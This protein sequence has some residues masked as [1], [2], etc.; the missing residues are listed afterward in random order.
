LLPHFD[1]TRA[2][3]ASRV[4]D[5]AFGDS[6]LKKTS[7]IVRQAL[8][9]LGPRPAGTVWARPGYVFAVD[10]SLLLTSVLTNAVPL[11]ADHIGLTRLAEDFLRASV[12]ILIVAVHGDELGDAFPHDGDARRLLLRRAFVGA[13]GGAASALAGKALVTAIT[14]YTAVINGFIQVSAN[15]KTT[16]MF[17]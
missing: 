7:I 8:R 12:G 3:C 16:G 10:I 9:R 13:V 15:A 2:K 11:R 4:A 1:E 17:E 5:T 6:L 14:T